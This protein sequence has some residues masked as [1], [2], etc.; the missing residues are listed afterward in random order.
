MSS[1]L[2]SMLESILLPFFMQNPNMKTIAFKIGEYYLK[3]KRRVKWIY[4]DTTILKYSFSCSVFSLNAFIFWLSILGDA[5]YGSITL[6]GGQ[7]DALLCNFLTAIRRS[8]EHS[9]LWSRYYFRPQRL[10]RF[11]CYQKSHGIY[12][13][14]F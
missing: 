1:F 14:Q 9:Q 11:G 8:F 5:F 2:K 12:Q 10:L 13:I 3:T 6:S 4:F 7:V